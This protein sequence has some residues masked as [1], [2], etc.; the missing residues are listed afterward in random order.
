LAINYLGA[1]SAAFIGRL[2]ELAPFRK[3]LYSSDGFGPAELQYLGARLWRTGILDALQGFVD[4]DEWSERDAIRV[5][6]LVA[7]EN[8]RRVY[9]LR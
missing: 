4:A 1:R 2:L 7:H 5:V 8:A 3:I 9:A 6:D